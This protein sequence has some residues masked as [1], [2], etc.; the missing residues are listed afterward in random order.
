M[1]EYTSCLNF[2]DEAWWF[3]SLRVFRLLSSSLLLFP[4]R[5]DWYVL[6]PSSGICWTWE[7]TQNFELSFI[8][9]TG[10]ACCRGLCGNNNKDEDNSPKTLNDKKNIWVKINDN[11]HWQCFIC[12]KNKTNIMPILTVKKNKIVQT[13]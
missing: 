4:Q 13:Q 10:V 9:S 1:K 6:R 12:K 5:F 7:P 3:L 2:C 8:E 11:D